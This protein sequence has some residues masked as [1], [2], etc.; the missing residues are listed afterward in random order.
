MKSHTLFLLLPVLFLACKKDKAETPDIS[1]PSPWM[2][3]PALS[4]A[5]WYSQNTPAPLLEG[6]DI[7]HYPIT[8]KSVE[9]Q[10]YFDQGLLLAYAFN[11]AEAAR[12]FYQSI[13]LDS[14][15]AMCYWGLPMS[16]ALITMPA[17]NRII[18]HGLMMPSKRRIAMHQE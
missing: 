15:C 9:A 10:K 12:S 6:M 11:H 16:S 8:T 1:K 7:L 2:C 13:R 4:D 14:T 5:D 17:W 3:T 18:T